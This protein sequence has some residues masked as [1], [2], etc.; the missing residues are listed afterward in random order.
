MTLLTYLVSFSR[1]PI[2]PNLRLWICSDELRLG[3]PRRQRRILVQ[4]DQFVGHGRDTRHH[5]DRRKAWN[6]L[7]FSIA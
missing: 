3:L 5:Q 2:H 1:E 4:S 6:Y 7:R